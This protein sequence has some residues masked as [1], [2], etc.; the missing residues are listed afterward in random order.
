MSE[1]MSAPTSASK[2]TTQPKW[3]CVAATIVAVMML[4]GC[5]SSG[6]ENT[7]ESAGSKKSDSKFGQGSLKTPTIPHAEIDN[8]GSLRVRKEG[9]LPEGT[10][11]SGAESN[12]PWVKVNRFTGEVHYDPK[13]SRIK[14]GNYDVTVIAELPS[15]EVMDIDTTVEIVTYKSLQSEVESELPE[16]P[17]LPPV[18]VRPGESVTVEL[19]GGNLPE[20]TTYREGAG[21]SRMRVDEFT[22]AV[23]YDLSRSTSKYINDTLDVSVRP[24]LPDGYQMSDIRSEVRIV[25]EP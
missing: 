25:V 4:A 5:G 20:G 16:L 8:W 1:L 9:E 19:E 2:N 21:P 6:A 3:R 10:I 18:T 13:D 12:Q 15:G 14:L 24:T 7:E 23:T 11:Y 17:T 22:G